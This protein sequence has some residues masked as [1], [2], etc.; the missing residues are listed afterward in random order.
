MNK[1]PF[2]TIITPTYQSQ[3]TL[4][5]TIQ[6]VL[7]LNFF[8]YEYI[9]IDGNSTDNTLNIIKDYQKL[10][11]KKGINYQYVSKPDKGIYDAWNIGISLSS[12]KW[13]SFLGSDDLYLND[14]LNNYYQAILNAS[15][16]VNYISSKINIINSYGHVIKT[17]GKPFNAQNIIKEMNIAQV[18]SFH[19]KSLFYENNLFSLDYKIVGDLDFYLKSYHI[20]KPF[21]VNKIT[22]NMGNNGVSNNI[23]KA[24][25]EALTVRLKY[26]YH[27]K[28]LTYCYHSILLLKCYINLW[29]NKKRA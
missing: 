4:Q 14:A 8:D 2:F 26:H 21:F 15:N 13:I 5:K 22:A 12:G 6:S 1:T 29:I 18:G 20:I 10:F 28:I 7:D 3:K 19:H 27:S 17:F 25:N 16:D 9:I 23:Q 11:I 24:L